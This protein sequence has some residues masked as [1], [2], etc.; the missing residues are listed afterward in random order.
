MRQTGELHIEIKPHVLWA[1]KMVARFARGIGFIGD[2]LEQIDTCL[3]ELAL[4]L[5][6]KSHHGGRISFREIAENKLRGLELAIHH[7]KN[8][9]KSEVILARSLKAIEVFAD[10]FEVTSS[11]GERRIVIR[12]YLDAPKP[13]EPGEGEIT[14]SVQVRNHPSSAVCGDGY[15]SVQK[16][17]QIL[18]AVIDGLGHGSEARKASALAETYLNQNHEEPLLEIPSQ[19][20]QLLRGSRGAVAGIARIDE[21]RGK[22]YFVGVGNIDAKLWQAGAGSWDRLTCIGGVLGHNL[23]NLVV[24]SFP[25]NRGNV[26]IMHSDGIKPGWELSCRT[27]SSSP[28]DIAASIMRSHWRGTD[29]ATVMVAR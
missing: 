3:N 6:Q 26:L 29:D 4:N 9:D 19:L 10:E 23:P 7:E 20:H 5:L 24:F 16:G 15:V 27:L 12:K 28:S 1:R 8:G 2:G 18:L 17:S 13:C 11:G 22:L 25:W 14:V 21:K